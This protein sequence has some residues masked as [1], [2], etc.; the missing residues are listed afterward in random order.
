MKQHTSKQQRSLRLEHLTTTNL[1]SSKIVENATVL[2]VLKEI[3]LNMISYGQYE[4]QERGVHPM[5]K[6]FSLLVAYY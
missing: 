3:T 1:P 6:C 5:C 2:I 4:H